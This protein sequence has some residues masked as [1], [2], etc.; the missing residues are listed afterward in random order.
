[1]KKPVRNKGGFVMVDKQFE[2]DLFDQLGGEQLDESGFETEIP[3]SDSEWRI[4]NES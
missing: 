3:E 4:P 2:P 1:M